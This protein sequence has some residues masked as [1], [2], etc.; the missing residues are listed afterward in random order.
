MAEGGAKKRSFQVAFKLKVVEAAESTSNRGAARRF[1]VDEANIPYWR[2]QKHQLETTGGKKRLSGAGRKAKL[3]DMEDQLASWVMELRSRNCRVTRGAIQLK[4]LELHQVDE[5][6]S[7]SRGWLEKFFKRHDFSLRRRTTVC[8]KLPQDHI[9]K[10]TSYLMRVRKMRHTHQY[11]LSSIGNMDE[12]PLWLDMPGDTTVTQVGDRSVPIRTTG[13]DKG[14][15]T[16]ILSAMANGNKL[17]PFV[18]FKG[19]SPIS[20]LT[21][22]PGAVVMMSRNGWMNE[23]LTLVYLDK[24]WGQ[25]SFVRRLLI[26]QVC[27]W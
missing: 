18:V 20:E 27:A 13:H 16:V 1:G 2:K 3:P 6:F 22:H 23:D 11:S 9:T 10:I 12:T 15:F 4:A 24:V 14:R 5:E 8:Q 19:V 25:L 26:I 17:K 7:A 21:R